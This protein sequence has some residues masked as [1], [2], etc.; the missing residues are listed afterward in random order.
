MNL[1][2]QAVAAVGAFYKIPLDSI[3]V[4]LD[5]FAL[6]LG[7]LRFRPSGSAGGHHG[8]QSVIEHLGTQAVARLRV[9]IGAAQSQDPVDHVLGRFRPE[10]KTLLTETL[11]RAVDGIECAQ[12]MGISAAM[13]AFN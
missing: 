4:V 11:D 1:S 5:D 9:G 8:L 13:N 12:S 3:L 10:E 7:K 6:P 2:G